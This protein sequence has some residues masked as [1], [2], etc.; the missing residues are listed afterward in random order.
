M[1]DPLTIALF[2]GASFVSAF[3]WIFIHEFSHA[4]FAWFM[5]A[6]ITHFRPYPN[7]LP[8]DN[9]PYWVLGSVG[10]MYP[11]DGEHPKDR[12]VFA[13]PLF[14]SIPLAFLSLHLVASMR[15]AYFFPF[16]YFFTLDIVTWML[17]YVRQNNPRT[18]GYRFRNYE[19]NS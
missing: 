10:Y 16:F 9:G 2:I 4:A 7:R 1:F 19:K 6:E 18:D 8:G 5:G 15:L 17:D 3:L 12:W 14:F 13:S 11:P